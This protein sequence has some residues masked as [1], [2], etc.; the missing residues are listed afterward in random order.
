MSFYHI[1][2]ISVLALL[3]SCATEQ[4]PKAEPASHD[5][6][7]NIPPIDNMIVNQEVFTFQCYAPILRRDPPENQCQTEL[8]QLLER[9]YHMNYNQNQVNMASDELFLPRRGHPPPQMVR[10]DPEVR[11]SERRFPQ[12]G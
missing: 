7:H 5:S 9:R 2:A 11:P 10:T 4:M 8:F 3:S 12:R 1:V 6:A